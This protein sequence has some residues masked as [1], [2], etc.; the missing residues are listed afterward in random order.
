MS[1][2]NPLATMTDMPVA[3]TDDFDLVTSSKAYL[4]RLQLMTSNSASCKA[5]DFPV[6]HYARVHDSAELDLD[7]TVDCLVC[8]WRPLALETQAENGVNA[9]YDPKSDDFIRVQAAADVKTSGDEINGNLYGP[10]FLLW[11]PAQKEFVAFFMSSPTARRASPSVKALIGKAA[12][13]GSKKIVGKKFSWFGPTC[14]E[15]S[16]PFEMPTEDEA[17][18][19]MTDFANPPEPV[20]ETVAAEDEATRE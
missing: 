19:A 7:V 5:G 9:F 14:I 18:Q 6:N 12:T 2:E 1:T 4:P 3:M 11:L 16:T 20:I 13:L 17:R 15:C 8:A 10:Q